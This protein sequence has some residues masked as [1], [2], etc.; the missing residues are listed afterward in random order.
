MCYSRT[1]SLRKYRD[2][3]K[4]MD[5]YIV[6]A[7]VYTGGS[8]EELEAEFYSTHDTFLSLNQPIKIV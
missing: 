1:M 2:L 5:A 8:P 6:V 7:Y 3:K 4:K